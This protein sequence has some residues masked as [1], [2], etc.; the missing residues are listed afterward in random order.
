MPLELRS[1]HILD[2][3]VRS[4]NG[5]HR[6]RKNYN[7]A[8]SCQGT[9]LLQC[10][11]VPRSGDDRLVH[12]YIYNKIAIAQDTFCACLDMRWACYPRPLFKQR[13]ILVLTRQ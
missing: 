12:K 5:G 2:R 11:S 3:L 10:C 8:R 7:N 6:G 9:V 13:H 1:N 4:F